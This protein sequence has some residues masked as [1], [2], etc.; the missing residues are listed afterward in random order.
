M[1][2]YFGMKP[3]EFWNATFREVSKFC[4]VNIVRVHDEFRNEIIVQEAS[5]DKLL[6]GDAMREKPKIM[7]LK[8]MFK[9][10]FKK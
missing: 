1:A 5:T 8:K 2:Y 6:M 9:N 4:E 10:L 3:N 7:P